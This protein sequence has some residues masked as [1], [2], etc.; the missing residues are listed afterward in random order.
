M[1]PDGQYAV[2]DT[3][4]LLLPFTDGT[5]IE[6][7]LER[8]FGPVQMVVPSSIAQELHGL[9]GGGNAKAPRAAKAAVKLMQRF[10]IE[11]TPLKGDDG[12]LEVARRLKAVVVT[13]DRKVRQEAH[14]SGLKVAS[15]RGKGRLGLERSRL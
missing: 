15:S 1:N 7:E 4:A 10:H 9:A 5:D 6:K 2:I 3:N 12:V 8:L 13:N 14:R 11:Q